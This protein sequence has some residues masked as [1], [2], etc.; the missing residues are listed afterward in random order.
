[1]DG[2]ASPSTSE[3]MSVTTMTFDDGGS[4]IRHRRRD[5][6]GSSVLSHRAPETGSGRSS[7]LP[8][9]ATSVVVVVVATTIVGVLPPVERHR[10]RGSIG[11]PSHLLAATTTT[12]WS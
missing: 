1:M 5:G 9:I 11:R 12:L 4:I 10:H 2:A 3:T 6:Y 7:S 8:P